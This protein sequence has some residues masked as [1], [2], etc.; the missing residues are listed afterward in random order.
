MI[1][2]RVSGKRKADA[3]HQVFLE[4]CVDKELRLLHA[5]GVLQQGE[6]LPV[7]LRDL[8]GDVPC[9]CHDLGAGQDVVDMG[10]PALQLAAP[11]TLAAEH[12]LVCQERSDELRQ[13][14]GACPCRE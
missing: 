10:A 9:L 13:E 7:L 5:Q 14:G 3:V 1:V 12:H 4:P 2:R 6:G 11:E 8:F